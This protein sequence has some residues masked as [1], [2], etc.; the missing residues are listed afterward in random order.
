MPKDKG[1]RALQRSASSIWLKIGRM[2]ADGMLLQIKFLYDPKM[3]YFDLPRSTSCY[4]HVEYRW[5][6]CLILS[7][8][9]LVAWPKPTFTDLHRS[10]KVSEYSFMLQYPRVGCRCHMHITG[11]WPSVTSDCKSNSGIHAFHR[12]FTSPQ[13]SFFLSYFQKNCLRISKTGIPVK[14]ISVFKLLDLKRL[15]ST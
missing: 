2:L 11:R 9:I 6:A 8:E 4:V 15:A 1:A 10:S 13:P 3:R 14:L 12:R 7:P 5:K